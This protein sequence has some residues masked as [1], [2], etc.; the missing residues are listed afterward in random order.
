MKI[1][2]TLKK[3]FLIE[4]ESKWK[5]VKR[6]RSSFLSKYQ[7]FLEKE[8]KVHE[9]LLNDENVEPE[10]KANI[11]NDPK[12]AVWKRKAYEDSSSK[13]KRRRVIETS[14]NFSTDQLACK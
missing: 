8:W 10:I 14:S 3:D 7:T 5:S 12:K 9:D 13:T 2:N 4:Y 6:T 11:L 1:R